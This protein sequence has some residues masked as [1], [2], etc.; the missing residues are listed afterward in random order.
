M[1]ADEKRAPGGHYSGRN[2]IPNI[3]RFIESLDSDKRN[4]DRE[5]EKQLQA[6]RTNLDV[7]DHKE[8]KPSAANNNRKTVT[9]PTTGNQVQIEN[10]DKDFMKAVENPMLS[11]PNANLG[12]ETTV[13]TD[14]SQS[15]QEYSRNQ[16]ITAPPDPIYP[17]STSDV[18]I[19]G[20]K[21]NILF[22]PTPSVSYEPMYTAIE[23][24]ASVLCISVLVAIV[25]LGKMFGG[26]LYGLIPLGMCIS[27][28]VFL[29]MKEVVRSGR[30]IEWS[31]EQQR[32]ETV[33]HISKCLETRRSFS[34]STR[35]PQT[36]FPNQSN[37]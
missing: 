10:V 24:R 34:Y 28:G 18:P 4:R 27:S 17:G 13:K 3:Q 23:N 11:V 22:H 8:E 5:I 1:A 2:P 20:E 21:T 15:G 33:R 16:D 37:G 9:D 25:V 12:K 26:A 35:P 14:K 30:E 7:V 29:W 36:S 31:S 32:G 6:T 19:H